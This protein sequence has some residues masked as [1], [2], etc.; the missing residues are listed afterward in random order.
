MVK[1]VK[2]FKIKNNLKEHMKSSHT[3]GKNYTCEFCLKTFKSKNN[4]K[5]HI[6]LHTDEK[7]YVCAMCDFCMLYN[8]YSMLDMFV[9]CMTFVC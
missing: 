8:W 1:N 5:G 4:L 9:P 6:R 2:T 3:D 7:K